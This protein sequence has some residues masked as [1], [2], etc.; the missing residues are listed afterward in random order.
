[1][2]TLKVCPKEFRQ[3][4][5]DLHTETFPSDPLPTWKKSGMAWIVYARGAPV[6]FLYA[7][8]TDSGWY[9]SRVGVTAAARGR[10]LQRKLMRLMVK[11][12]PKGTFIYSTTYQNPAS[13]NNFVLAKWLTYLPVG[14]WGA[15][16]TIYWYTY[17]AA[18]A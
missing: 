17:G 4:L 1:M 14:P 8:P 10:G 9:F 15:P 5:T 12:L 3:V 16:D 2:R 11:A 7:E 13:A 6:A 18:G